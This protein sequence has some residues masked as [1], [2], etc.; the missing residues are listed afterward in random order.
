MKS[1]SASE[2]MKAYQ[3]T[4][5]LLKQWGLQPQLHQLDKEASLIL[6]YFITREQMVYQLTPPNVKHSNT[7]ERELRTFKNHLIA[8]LCSVDP[9]FPLNLWDE[10]LYQAIITLSLL[11]ASRIN[12]WL[13]AYAQVHGAFNFNHTPLAPPGTRVLVH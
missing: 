13:S 6:W 12:P 7:V 11:C 5:T 4:I 3:C 10:I 1:R 9:N 2:H 8:G